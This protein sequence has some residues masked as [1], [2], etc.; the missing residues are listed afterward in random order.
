MK[1]IKTLFLILLCLHFII[2]MKIN[3]SDVKNVNNSSNN[4]DKKKGPVLTT[5]KHRE[6]ESENESN[7]VSKEQ[8]ISNKKTEK[9]KEKEMKKAIAIAKCKQDTKYCPETNPD[10]IAK[11]D[12]KDKP[13]DIK[14]N[15][16]DNTPDNGNGVSTPSTPTPDSTPTPKPSPDTPAS[17]TPPKIEIHGHETPKTEACMTKKEYDALQ[18]TSKCSVTYNINVT[19]LAY[20]GE[21]KFFNMCSSHCQNL[22]AGETWEEMNP[23]NSGRK[24]TGKV[25]DVN[26]KDVKI[27]VKENPKAKNKIESSAEKYKLEKSKNSVESEPVFSEINLEQDG[28]VHKFNLDPTVNNNIK[29]VT[30]NDVYSEK[31]D[32]YRLHN[33][34]VP[35][36]RGR[37]ESGYENFK[38]VEYSKYAKVEQL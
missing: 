1:I 32:E 36:Y 31:I 23:G 38:K 21:G 33:M 11:N 8:N 28:K 16:G 37:E 19:D 13:K 5:L 15:A 27:T 29:E 26:P 12:E 6:T 14:G 30:S 25:N 2:N 9:E 7:K 3:H 35:K 10:D 17:V 4:K 20:C 18:F 34:Q 22:C 24:S